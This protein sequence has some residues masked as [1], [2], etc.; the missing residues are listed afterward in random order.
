MKWELRIEIYFRVLGRSKEEV[1]KKNKLVAE[2]EGRLREYRSIE[3][4]YKGN[5]D[6]LF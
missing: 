4:I 2:L 5:N 6:L 3:L 1:D